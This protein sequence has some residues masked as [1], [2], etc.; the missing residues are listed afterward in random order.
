M[1][2]SEEEEDSA[3]AARGDPQDASEPDFWSISDDCVMIHHRQARI[4]LYVPDESTFPIPLK[5]I[6]VMRR[7]YT[8]IDSAVETNR[9]LLV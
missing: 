6:D 9:R 8:D 1:K 7:T 2:P 3:D 4:K 5:Y